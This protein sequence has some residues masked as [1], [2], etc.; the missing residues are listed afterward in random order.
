MSR[1]PPRPAPKATTRAAPTPAPTS[2]ALTPTHPD[3]LP[4][5]AREREI[6]GRQSERSER[7]HRREVGL[8]PTGP[9]CERRWGGPVGGASRP[10]PRSER[11]ERPSALDVGD[12]VAVA[13]A[14]WLFLA[15]GFAVRRAG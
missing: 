6:L 12:R 15:A 7:V 3:P 5:F 11:S 4:R 14:G 10:L 1:L 9:P 8:C 2:P 13:A